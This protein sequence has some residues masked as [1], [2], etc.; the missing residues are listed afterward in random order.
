MENTDL[1]NSVCS[2]IRVFADYVK[3]IYNSLC[4]VYLL[5]NQKQSFRDQRSGPK[6]S[7]K[8][9][10]HNSPQARERLIKYAFSLD[11]H[12]ILLI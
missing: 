10:F 5:Q 12:C 1:G 9:L 7:N 4:L 11:R 3:I 8:S 6:I 2:K